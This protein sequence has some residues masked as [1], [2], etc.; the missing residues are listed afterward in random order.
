MLKL[1]GIPNCDTVK[2]T[3]KWLDQHGIEY[4][5]HD[6]KIQGITKKQLSEWCKQVEWE[7]LLNK[8]SRTWKELNA[9]KIDKDSLSNFTQTKAIA[10]MQ[11]HPTLIKRPVAQ[12]GKTITVG[13]DEKIYQANFQ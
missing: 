13:F 12:E 5:F 11:K 4:E 8:R 2:K 1:F 3:Q 6:Y 10:L 9:K 7:T